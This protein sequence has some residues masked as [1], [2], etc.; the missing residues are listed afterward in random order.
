MNLK[1]LKI[2]HLTA[3][4]PVIQGGMGIGVSLNS[5]A[6][7]VAKCGGIGVISAAQIGFREPDFKKNTV[8][9]NLR[10][11]EKEITLA[12]EKSPDGII[13][14]NLMVAMKNYTDYVKKSVAEKVD[15]IISG[16][17]LPLDLPKFTKGSQTQIAPIVSSAKATK[18]ICKFWDTK[19]DYTPDA[20]IIEGPLAGGHL[21]FYEKDMENPPNVLDILQEVRRI[22]APYE[23]K[24]NKKIPLIIAGGIYNAKDIEEALNAGADGVQMGTRFVTTHECDASNNFKEAY[25]NCK[26]ENIVLTKSPVGMTGRAINNKFLANKKGNKACYYQCLHKCDVT[27]I[28]YCITEALIQSVTGNVDD[29][30]IF[31]GSKANQ[32]TQLEHVTDVF[33][34]IKLHFTRLVHTQE[35]L[36]NVI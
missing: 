15:I 23:L 8:N 18:I 35:S 29:G 27:T 4:F 7:A 33:T 20:I 1:P 32:A 11:L 9:A 14:V 21:G 26:S 12:K 30:L 6:S 19:H 34:E 31:C 28:P 25:I 24:Y 10:A 16:A 36:V 2:G 17:G 13:G 3:N 22:I 5:L